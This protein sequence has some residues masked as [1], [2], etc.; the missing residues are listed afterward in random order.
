MDYLW[1]PWRYHYV[2]TTAGEGGDCIFCAAGR[3]TEDK[4]R[5]VVFRATHNFVILNRFPYTC[6]HIMVVPYA[7]VDTLD[8]LDDAALVELIRLTRECEQHLRSIYHPDGLNIG[9]NIGRSAGAGVAGHVHMHVLPRW[10]G[11]VSFL[12]S[13]SETRVLPEV[14][15]ITWEKLHQAFQTKR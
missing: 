10:V 7:H 12:T 9:M 2:T 8:A 4:E 13:V 15:E 1:T 3:G 6:G 5:L 14:L 11:D